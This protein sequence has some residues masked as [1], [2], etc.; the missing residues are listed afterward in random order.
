MA[1]DRRPD[2]HDPLG[3][4]REK[5]SW[6]VYLAGILALLALI[7]V[8]QNSQTVEFKFFFVDG[9]TPLFFG[10]IIAF[11]LG[12]LVGWLL[13]RVRGGGRHRDAEKD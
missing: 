13:P 9:E 8:I 11:M 3:R 6:R 4:S 12:A 2:P 5:R 7:L 10:L 1:N